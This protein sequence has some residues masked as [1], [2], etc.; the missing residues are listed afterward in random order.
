[1]KRFKSEKGFTMLE[2]IVVSAL[3]ALMSAILYGTLN[4]IM[5]GQSLVSSGRTD[6]R[7]A[8]YVF[9]RLGTELSSRMAEPLAADKNASSSG[10]P[11]RA[12][13]RAYMFGQ[14]KQSGSADTDSLRF[15]SAGAAQQ[16]VGGGGNHG[17]VEIEYRLEKDPDADDFRL[18]SDGLAQSTPRSKRVSSWPRRRGATKRTNGNLPRCSQC[19]LL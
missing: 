5:R 14:N 10:T 7:V 15:V 12:S 16:I 6:Y 19:G 4:G 9:N 2:L 17:L 13:R 11:F 1:M 18:P 3:L 8:R